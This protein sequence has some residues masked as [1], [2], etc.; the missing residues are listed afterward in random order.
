MQKV[1]ILLLLVLVLPTKAMA[2]T[3]SPDGYSVVFVNGVL[4]DQGTAESNKVALEE[5][6]KILTG[7]NDVTFRLG[8]NLSHLAGGGDAYKSI[9]QVLQKP[10]ATVVED[11]DLQTILLRIHP[12]VTTQKILLVGHSQGT[13]YTNAIYRYLLEHGTS[14]SSLAVYNLATPASYVEGGG[15]YLTSANDKLINAARVWTASVGARNP[16][17]ANITIPLPANELSDDWGGHHFSSS[18]LDAAPDRIVSDITNALGKLKAGTQSSSDGCFAPPPADIAYRT[19]GLAFKAMDPT[20]AVLKDGLVTAGNSAVAVAKTVS[21]T[22]ANAAKILKDALTK[23]LPTRGGA[24]GGQTA[25]AAS[26]LTPASPPVVAKTNTPPT[27]RVA[28]PSTPSTGSGQATPTLA[29]APA[30]QIV[31]PPVVPPPPQQPQSPIIPAP[32]TVAAGFG[33]GGGGASESA[34]AEPTP[35][36]AVFV[37]LDVVSPLE[38]ATFATASVTFTG[39][40]TAGFLV[41]GTEGAEA[42][43]TIADTDGNWTLSFILPEGESEVSFSADDGA[44]NMSDIATRTVTVDTTGPAAP[45]LSISECA[46]SFTSEICMIATTTVTLMWDAVPDAAYYGVGDA[47]TTDTTYQLTALSNRVETA[48]TVTAFDATGNSTISNEAVVLPF[49]LAVTINELTWAGTKASAEDEWLELANN[50]DHN[51]DLTHFTLVSADGGLTIPLTGSIAAHGFFLIERRAEATSQPH[52]LVTAFEP[53]SDDGEQ[54]LLMLEDGSDLAVFDQTPP[55]ET[56]SGW[57]GGTGTA[58]EVVWINS[59]ER[60]ADVFGAVGSESSAWQTY[61]STADH[62]T[63]ADGAPINGTPRTENSTEPEELFVEF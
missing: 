12:Q 52:D 58:E 47:T 18:Y 44:G 7:R 38:G 62:A 36:A 24:S 8:Y 37:P 25:A 35:T 33:G 13:F 63:D 48:V 2:Q 40:T 55:V 5:K 10:T 21:N 39:T 54:L 3:C 59:M 6:F 23:L 27:T 28:T 4:N 45:V 31:T 57:C 53:L 1:I 34:S 43:T 46:D 11:Y 22:M 56:C 32:V 60:V 30:P 61:G 9:Q 14:E 15:G 42:T 19:K 29:Q 41:A 17:P 20:M 49:T 16:L 50:T 26:A 51:I